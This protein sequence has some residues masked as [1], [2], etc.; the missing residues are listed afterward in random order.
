MSITEI[1]ADESIDNVIVKLQAQNIKDPDGFLSH[2]VWY[3]YRI[4]NPEKLIEA[5][6]T[7]GSV[8]FVNFSIP[9][10]RQ[11]GE[12]GFGVKLVD[13]DKGEITSEEI[14]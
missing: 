14:L 8:Q 6:V 5:K 7:P 2:L 4:E 9:K 13:N 3:Y 10:P 1:L 11:P 12:F